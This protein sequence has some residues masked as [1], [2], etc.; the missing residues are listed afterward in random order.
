MIL[1]PRDSGQVGLD[2]EDSDGHL[3]AFVTGG[4]TSGG[5]Y[6]F[7]TRTGQTVSL[8]M[9][10]PDAWEQLHALVLQS[11]PAPLIHASP[12]GSMVPY[13]RPRTGDI[14]LPLLPPPGGSARENG[15]SSG[16]YWPDADYSDRLALP[17]PEDREGEQRYSNTSG[18]RPGRDNEGPPAAN[19]LYGATLLGTLAFAV[20]SFAAAVGLYFR[21]SASPIEGQLRAGSEGSGTELV[22]SPIA[23]S[24]TA[25]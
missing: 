20:V 1:L 3:M 8:D 18:S 6:A 25:A 4:G 22:P 11:T 16:F 17:N 7:D 12:L 9:I 5:G 14:P 13:L 21:G 23:D 15:G 24:L 19:S 2:A 10:T